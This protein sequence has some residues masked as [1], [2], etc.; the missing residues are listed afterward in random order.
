MSCWQAVL[1]FWKEQIVA[2]NKKS[3]SVSPF[4]LSAAV[5][6]P[7][8]SVYGVCWTCIPVMVQRGLQCS[9][10]SWVRVRVGWLRTGVRECNKTVR[11]KGG[12]PRIQERTQSKREKGV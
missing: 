12:R 4:V 10:G 1:A 5:C 8:V 3:P 2:M 6:V 11:V 7:V 9:S